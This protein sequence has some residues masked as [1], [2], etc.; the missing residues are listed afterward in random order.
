MVVLYPVVIFCLTICMDGATGTKVKRAF[1][2]KEVI[3]SPGSSLLPCNCW[4]KWCVFLRWW[5]DW[6]TKGLMMWAS[7]LATP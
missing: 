2:S 3:T 6:S 1:T 5:G 4:I 7:S